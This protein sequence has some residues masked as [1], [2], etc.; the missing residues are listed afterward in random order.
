MQ[1]K[2]VVSQI[3]RERLVQPNLLKALLRS[4]K[5][6][7]LVTVEKTRFTTDGFFSIAKPALDISISK[8]GLTFPTIISLQPTG[9]RVLEDVALASIVIPESITIERQQITPIAKERLDLKQEFEEIQKPKPIVILPKQRTIQKQRKKVVTALLVEEEKVVT[10]IP[11]E[12]VKPIPKIPEAEKPTL[13]FVLREE[14]ER[15]E[16]KRKPRQGFDAQVKKKG[17]FV[18]INE[19]PLPKN[20]AL[21]LALREADRSP[22]VTARTVMAKR[23]TDVLIDESVDGILL[24]KFQRRLDKEGK[25]SVFVEKNM[26]RLDS[27][28]EL[29][30]I[31]KKGVSA[32][33]K[34][35]G[36]FM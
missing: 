26:F 4:K 30:G 15:I 11:I 2:F 3:S 23:P 28:G 1:F 18:T 29:R 19:M 27:L 10:Q 34:A 8:T 17:K 7:Q 31:Q 20:R 32:R 14:K 5:A 36:G 21:N 12:K 22:A 16:K 35:F 25:G 13:P 33:R 9:E 24:S 6:Q